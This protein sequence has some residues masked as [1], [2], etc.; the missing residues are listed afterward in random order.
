MVCALACLFTL[1]SVALAQND[2]SDAYVDPDGLF[3]VAIPTNWT[4]TPEDGFARLASPEEGIIIYMLALVGDDVPAA[5]DE[6]WALVDPDFDLE[7]V[8]VTT[9]DDPAL[10]AGAELIVVNTYQIDQQLYQAAGQLYE[11]VVYLLLLDGD[12]TVIQQRAAQ[13]QVINSGWKILA[14]EHDDLTGVEPLPVDDDI[15]AELESFINVALE[16]SGVPGLSVAIVQGDGVIYSNGFGVKSL[17]SQEPAT[18]QTLMMIGSTTK[19]MTTMMMAS[20]VDDDLL[21]WDEPVIDILP[22]FEVADPEITQTITVQNLVCACTGVPRRDFEIVFNQKDLTAE[23][24]IGQL[25]GFQFFTDFGEAFQYSNQM[26][27]TGG[28]IATLAA[29]GDYGDLYDSYVD[30][31]QE[32]IFDP[33]GMSGATFSIDDAVSSGDYA[34]PYG[35]N[36]AG[37]LYPSPLEL[38]E[39]V[40]AIA[41]AGGLWASANDMAKYLIAALNEGVAPDGTRVVSAENFMYTW[42]PQVQI[43]ADADYGLGWIIEDYKG[44]RVLS[45]DGLTIGYAAQI[46]L[47]PDADLGIVVLTNARTG[48]LLTSSVRARLFELV[49]DQEPEIENL[50]RFA[51]T[52]DNDIGGEFVDVDEAASTRFVGNFTN[53]ALGDISVIHEGDKFYLNTGDWVSEIRGFK[54][55]DGEIQYVLFDAPLNGVGITGG[56]D[57][58]DK[59]YVTIG[60][61]VVEYTFTATEE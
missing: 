23:D 55:N 49:Y 26:V 53:E 9:I 14:Q 3:S 5:I 40:R 57:A 36:A 60:G 24:I 20:L 19:T 18:S 8:D 46:A 54:S 41:P 6:A 32:R 2:D 11:G 10:T 42:T 1:S 27:A 44:L 17:D 43:S 35:Q 28:Y 47:L 31:M 39:F 7:P 58:D 16:L 15:I 30:L 52:Q 25:A 4:V 13:I 22:S 34:I 48:S 37:D 38:E 50:L 61:G 51:Y 29:G 59:P 12:L 45:H 21:Q 56:F 33:I